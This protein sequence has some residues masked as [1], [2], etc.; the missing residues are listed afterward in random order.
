M[1]NT[2]K[3]IDALHSVVVFTA[4]IFGA[5]GLLALFVIG[6]MCWQGWGKTYVNEMRRKSWL[7]ETGQ[8]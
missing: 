8:R 4:L 2:Q 3:L 7:K 1:T 6:W 5:V